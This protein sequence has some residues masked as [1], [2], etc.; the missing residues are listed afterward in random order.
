MKKYNFTYTPIKDTW[1]KILDKTASTYEEE[2][3]EYE[4]DKQSTYVVEATSKYEGTNTD[5][6]EL[7]EK[8]GERYVP[9]K[10]EQWK[11][12]YKRKEKLVELGF[13]NVIK[14]IKKEK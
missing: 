1:D 11:V 8:Y 14:Q 13:V 5:D 10:G 9:K 12:D 4:I 6:A 7:T 2:K 3:I